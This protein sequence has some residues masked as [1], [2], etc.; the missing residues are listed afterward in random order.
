ME[1]THRFVL[2]K[3]NSHNEGCC[4]N[5][6][7]STKLLFNCNVKLLKNELEIGS[8][9]SALL[10]RFCSPAPSTDKEIFGISMTCN[11]HWRPELSNLPSARSIAFSA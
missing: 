4:G 1:R 9:A 8:P 11:L 3:K 6:A 2:F 7:K 10:R 5:V